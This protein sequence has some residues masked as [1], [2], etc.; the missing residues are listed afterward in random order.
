MVCSKP[1]R[2]RFTASA[3]VLSLVAAA[4]LVASLLACAAPASVIAA[5][6]KYPT[7]YLAEGTIAWGFS[8]YITIENPN[9]SAETVRVTYMTNTGL[10]SR[11]DIVMP[12]MSHTTLWSDVIWQDISSAKDFSTKVECLSGDTIAVDRTM[13]WTG[14]GA[15]SEEGHSSIG[16]TSPEQSWYLPE[17]SSQWGFECW[18]LIQNP[19]PSVAHC[20]VTYMKDGGGQQV[21]SHDVPANS[22]KS[23][24][25]KDDIGEADA[26]IKV[27]S[28]VGV[29]PERAM[30]RNNRREGHDSIGVHNI[31]KQSYLAEGTT[32]WGFTTYVLIQNPNGLANRVTVTYMTPNGPV[33]HPE[34]PIVMAPY[35]RKTIRVNDYLPN[36]DFSTQVSG[37]DGA[38]IA[39]RAMYWN[40]GT[41]EACHDSIGLTEKH[42]TFYLP[43]GWSGYTPVLNKTYET[44][45]LVQNP[46]PVPVDVKVTY[47]TYNGVGN[48]TEGLNLLANS[49][50]SFNMA[51]KITDNKAAIMVESMTPGRKIIVERA[52]YW[53]NR[54]AGTDTI[55]GYSDP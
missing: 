29:I 52:M 36:T 9:A 28:D 3:A 21:V 38:V 43:D 25:M 41:G 55:G 22:R 17:G 14:P 40:N 24:N 23:Y 11:P 53:N 37:T 18:L 31:W 51:D 20:T 54:G 16:V 45:T 13:Y 39:E 34:D 30:Y 42:A 33:T 26:S 4:L 8:T 46:N 7:W 44:W 47:L 19:N 12:A 48:R 1:C 10:V 32:A 35:S 49:R 5:P 15:A 50:H 6:I 27:A 2:P